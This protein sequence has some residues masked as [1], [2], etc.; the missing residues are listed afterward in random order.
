MNTLFLARARVGADLAYSLKTTKGTYDFRAGLSYVYDYV[1]NGNAQYT[2]QN[3]SFAPFVENSV[4]T[5]DQRLVLNVGTNMQITDEVRLYVDFETSFL[6]EIQTKYQVNAG[7]RYSFGEKISTQAIETEEKQENIAPLK[8]Q[9][10]DKKQ[11][12]KQAQ[13]TKRKNTR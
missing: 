7:L 1:N 13:P 12:K 10:Q 3:S 11:D 5:S 9:D 8:I 2:I 6:G 4:I